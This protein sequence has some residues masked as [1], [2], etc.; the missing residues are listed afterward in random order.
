MKA[1]KP[2]MTL[3]DKEFRYCPF[4][5]RDHELSIYSMIQVTY[6]GKKKNIPMGYPYEFFRCEKNY[7][8]SKDSDF[9]D[10]ELNLRNERSEF[11]MLQLANEVLV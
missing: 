10:N 6:I 1:I 2:D 5:N 7:E 9:T 11:D 4:C 8:L 3:I